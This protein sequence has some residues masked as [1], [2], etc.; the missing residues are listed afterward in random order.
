MGHIYEMISSLTISEYK[1]RSHEFHHAACPRY[2]MTGVDVTFIA[3]AQIYLQVNVAII[4]ADAPK[5]SN[6]NVLI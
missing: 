2:A 1:P 6:D 5:C 4:I 3:M